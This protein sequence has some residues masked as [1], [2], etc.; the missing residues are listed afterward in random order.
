QYGE[1]QL[2]CAYRLDLV[3]EDSIVVEIK[4][5]ARWEP[6]HDAQIIS[7]LKLSGLHLGLVLNFNVKNI[8]REGIKRKV[9]NFPE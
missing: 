1:V 7:Y 3:V 2:S 8:S 5:V 9:N 6:V 4:S